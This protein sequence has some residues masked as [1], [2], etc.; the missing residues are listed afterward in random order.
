MSN[1]EDQIQALPIIPL[2]STEES[3]ETGMTSA[4]ESDSNSNK[5]LTGLARLAALAKPKPLPPN[6]IEDRRSVYWTDGPKN[7]NKD[8]NLT[9]RGKNLAQAKYPHSNY[10]GDRPSPIWKVTTAA[11]NAEAN[12]RIVKLA[13]AKPP[14]PDWVE[15]QSIISVLKKSSMVANPSDRIL[16]MA[17]PKAADP[18]F[19]TPQ[20]SKTQLDILQRDGRK[21]KFGPDGKVVENFGNDQKEPDFVERLCQPKGAPKG[22]RPDRPII[23]KITESM[24]NAEISNRVDEL[25]KMRRVGKRGVPKC[26]PEDKTAEIIFFDPKDGS[27]TPY[28]PYQVPKAAL[29]A[30]AKDRIN[31]LATPV[32]RKQRQKNQKWWVHMSVLILGG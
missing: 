8:Y 22:F 1:I 27:K 10:R 19:V 13:K 24:K 25:S 32:A 11:K 28:N 23:T 29:K 30:V 7:T 18:R 17:Q 15:D 14:H 20:I 21:R 6:F 2:S 12:D 9:E 16:A 5:P 4:V 31:E 26:M 3:E